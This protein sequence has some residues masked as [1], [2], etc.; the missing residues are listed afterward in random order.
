[1]RLDSTAS[2]VRSSGA[3]VSTRSSNVRLASSIIAHSSPVQVDASAPGRSS[4][5]SSDSPSELASRLAGSIVSTATFRPRAACPARSPPTSSSCRR[6]PSRRRCRSP[7]RASTRSITA[8]RSEL[9]ARAARPPRS[10]LAARTG[11]AACHRRPARR[12]RRRSWLRWGGRAGARR[13]LR[14]SGGRT[15]A[16]T[17]SSA[18]IRFGLLAAEALRVEAVRRP[19]RPG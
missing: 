13:A 3:C 15:P 7:C 10:E 5:P 9:A 11:K 2:R 14:A 18:E 12:R 4:L 1:M 6:R 16:G 19:P 8:S 17:T